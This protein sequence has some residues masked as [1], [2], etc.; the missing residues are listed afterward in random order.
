MESVFLGAT[1]L[2]QRDVFLHPVP[3]ALQAIHHGLADAREA[4]E[5]RRLEAEVVR[6]A[7]GF[8]DQRIGRSTIRIPP[9]VVG[10]PVR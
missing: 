7:R 8:D 4:F 3:R 2:E 10:G 6:L 1:R 5:L 9:S